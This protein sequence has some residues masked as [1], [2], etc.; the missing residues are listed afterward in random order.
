LTTRASAPA[1]VW[2]HRRGAKFRRAKTAMTTRRIESART[3]PSSDYVDPAEVDREN[4]CVFGRTWQLVGRTDQV[5]DEGSWFTTTVGNE[6]VIVCRDKGGTLRAL[7]AVCRHRAGPVAAGSGRQKVF[8]CGYHGWTYGL[9]GSLKGTPELDGVRNFRRAEFCL[10]SYRVET[11]GP[12]VFVNLSGTA[13]AIGEVFGEIVPLLESAF[14]TGCALAFRRDWEIACNWKVYVDNYLEG[15]HIPI[16]HPGL[17]REIDYAQYRTVTSR[18]SSEQIAPVRRPDR[19][20]VTDEARDAR[21]FWIYPNLMVNVY[22]DNLSTN[23]V[24]PLGHDRTLTVFEWYFP[25]PDD[26]GTR[27]RVD[28]TVAFSD[29]IQ[30]E[31]IAICEAVQRGLRAP[32]YES[33]R[34][35][36][37][38]E[39]GVFHF[40]KLYREAMER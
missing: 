33:G 16:V 20:R 34:Y 6:P 5:P 35:S 3:L 4:D 40:H 28:E 9:D 23:L 17:F 15:Y 1:V 38:R 31:D 26:A 13:P 7:S 29:E 30:L 11:I 32:S 39:N 24:L 12:L 36:V 10:P 21:Y 2:Y 27:A 14:A 37:A 19:I 25:R 18:W 22:A 8:V